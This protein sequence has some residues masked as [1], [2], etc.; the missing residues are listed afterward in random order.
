MIIIVQYKNQL[1]C[2]Q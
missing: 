1:A 2:L